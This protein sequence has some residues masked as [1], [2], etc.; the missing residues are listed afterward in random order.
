MITGKDMNKVHR[1]KNKGILGRVKK[2]LKKAD[3]ALQST[4]PLMP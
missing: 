2:K 3:D 1:Q 4:N